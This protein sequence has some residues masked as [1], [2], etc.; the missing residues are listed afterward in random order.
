[1]LFH[2]MFYC[3]ACDCCVGL[4]GTAGE[5]LVLFGELTGRFPRPPL[6]ISRAKVRLALEQGNGNIANS[7][8]RARFRKGAGPFIL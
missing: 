2:G 7:K 3:M 5:E 6:F 1:M 4:T 8:V